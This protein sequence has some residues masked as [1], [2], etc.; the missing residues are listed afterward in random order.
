MAICLC[1]QSILPYF[2]LQFNEIPGNS[3]DK[4]METSPAF[5]HPLW[6]NAGKKPLPRPE[7]GQQSSQFPLYASASNTAFIPLYVS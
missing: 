6:Q 4:N 5:S 2:C 1:M 3:F 7:P